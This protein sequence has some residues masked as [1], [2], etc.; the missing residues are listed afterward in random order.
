MQT[1]HAISVLTHAVRQAFQPAIDFEHRV[2]ARLRAAFNE[3]REF[4]RDV[5]TA[6][7][8]PDAMS[9]GDRR[10]DEMEICVG[11]VGASAG[12]VEGPIGPISGMAAIIK[13]LYH[14][15]RAGHQY[16][17][18]HP[19]SSTPPAPASGSPHP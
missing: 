1:P 14:L 10:M 3:T 12:I 6:L 17:I 13:G 19:V 18:S 5:V 8:C 4:K 7:R 16:R 11:V 15:E 2:A 9:P